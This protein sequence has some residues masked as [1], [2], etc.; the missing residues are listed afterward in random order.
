MDG[1]SHTCELAILNQLRWK[2]TN[3]STAAK[4]HLK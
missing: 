4:M 3:E 2:K 1:E